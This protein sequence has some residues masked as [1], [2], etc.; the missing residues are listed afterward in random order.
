MNKV[1]KDDE[2]Y[3]D[4]MHKQRLESKFMQSKFFEMIEEYHDVLSHM[5]N[6]FGDNGN[7]MTLLI[8]KAVSIKVNAKETASTKAK[9]R[10]ISNSKK[11]AVFE[12]DKYRCVKCDSYIDLTIDLIIQIINGGSNDLDNLQTLCKQCNSSKCAKDNSEFMQL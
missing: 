6:D 7:H 11:K 9:R 10:K 8:E 1:I 4:Y 5:W 12:N 2:Q 3:Y